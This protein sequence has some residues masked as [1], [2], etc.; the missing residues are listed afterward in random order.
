MSATIVQRW[1]AEN[2][3]ELGAYIAAA[4]TP[5]RLDLRA[6]M[7]LHE[8]IAVGEEC[9]PLN[10]LGIFD[11]LLGRACLVDGFVEGGSAGLL[12]ARIDIGKLPRGIHLHA[13]KGG[14]SPAN[15]GVSGSLGNLTEDQ[16][17][18]RFD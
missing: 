4:R 13:E 16:G 17:Q 10:A 8:R 9:L 11:S 7:P 2:A 3:F 18:E 14:L 6:L 1:P 15:G 12:E 5:E